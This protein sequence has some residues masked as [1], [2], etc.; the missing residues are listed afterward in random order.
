MVIVFH[1]TKYVLGIIFIERAIGIFVKRLTVRAFETHAFAALLPVLFIR[2]AVAFV[3]A[4]AIA[5]VAFAFIAFGTIVP[6]TR[7]FTVIAQLI[8]LALVRLGVGMAIAVGFIPNLFS[9]STVFTLLHEACY[10]LH[11]GCIDVMGQVLIPCILPRLRE[12]FKVL[13]HFVGTLIGC[14]CTIAQ[15]NSIIES[16]K[17]RFPTRDCALARFLHKGN[18]FDLG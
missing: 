9:E 7:G 8:I 18:A 17:D 5:I 1:I 15:F 16:L 11:R 12:G 13:L 10:I 2:V 6:A 3:L 14:A 4:F